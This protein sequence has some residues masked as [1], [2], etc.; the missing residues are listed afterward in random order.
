M[1]FLKIFNYGTMGM[2][3]SLCLVLVS[4]LNV[5]LYAGSRHGSDGNCGIY[6]TRSWS[7]SDRTIGLGETVTVISIF[8]GALCLVLWALLNFTSYSKGKHYAST[9]TITLVSLFLFAFWIVP[10]SLLA[11]DMANYDDL[12]GQWCQMPYTW[13]ATLFFSLFE[14]LL[15]F[16]MLLNG[17]LALIIDQ[18]GNMI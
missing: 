1:G 7:I 5:G 6:G 18:E 14:W 8:L 17:A 16:L 9:G 2:F 11:K 10:W 3:M 4:T 12:Y 13:S 15:W